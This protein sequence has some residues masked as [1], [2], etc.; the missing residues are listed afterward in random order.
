MDS[1]V[2]KRRNIGNTKPIKDQKRLPYRMVVDA[3]VIKQGAYGVALKQE[4]K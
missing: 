4:A 1:I 3:G 2:L